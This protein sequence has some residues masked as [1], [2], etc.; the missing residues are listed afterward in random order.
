V[1]A[2]LDACN[3]RAVDSKHVSNICTATLF[4]S[5]EKLYN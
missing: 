1:V 4:P 3:L 5:Q 2:E